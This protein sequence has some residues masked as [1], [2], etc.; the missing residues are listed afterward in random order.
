MALLLKAGIRTEVVD[1]TPKKVMYRVLQTMPDNMHDWIKDRSGKLEAEIPVNFDDDFSRIIDIVYAHMDRLPNT[2]PVELGSPE[3]PFVDAVEDNKT[4]EAPQRPE[5]VPVADPEPAKAAVAKKPAG[6]AKKAEKKES[7]PD[8]P[9]TTGSAEDLPNCFECGS[10]VEN[11]DI[12]DISKI[13]FRKVMCKSCF[14]AA[15]KTA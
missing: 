13:R 4:R 8:K 11:A 3:H 10:Q 6:P 14:Q 7:E 5:T 1:N 2:A 12:R 15:K 9:A